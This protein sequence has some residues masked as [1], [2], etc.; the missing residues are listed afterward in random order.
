MSRA[1]VSLLSLL[2]F[3]ATAAAQTTLAVQSVTVEGGASVPVTTVI[4]VQQTPVSVV[5]ST[6]VTVPQPKMTRAQRRAR[7]ADEFAYRID[8]LVRSRN[9]VF[10]PNSVQEI[11][12]GEMQIIYADYYYF[13]V[14]GDNVEVHLPSVNGI[15]QFVTM[16]NFDSPVADY[17]M[18]PFQSGV[19]TTFTLQQSGETV[20]CRF[21]ISTVTGQTV[22]TLAAPDGAMRY[23][24]RLSAVRRQNEKEA[25]LL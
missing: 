16:L 11:P 17:R 23:V 19:T 8:S 18:F 2:S 13:G 3:V 24:G 6:V 10:Y 20:F 22:L 7:K 12:D 25:E 1:A 15:T 9:F 4:P 21:V 5:D 14:S